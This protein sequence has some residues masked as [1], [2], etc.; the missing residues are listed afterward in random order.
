VHFLDTQ[1]APIL[2]QLDVYLLLIALV[3]ADLS[4]YFDSIP[5]SELIKSVARRIVDRQVLHLVK[6]WLIAPV[7]EDDGCGHRKR[8][9]VNRDTR[10]GTPQGSPVC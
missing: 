2:L 10:R 1:I 8:T 5:H 4:G 9:T 7:E 3:D 6:Q